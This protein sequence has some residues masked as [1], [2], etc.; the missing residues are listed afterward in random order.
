MSLLAASPVLG[1]GGLPCVPGSLA[2]TLGLFCPH[3]YLEQVCSPQ[4]PWGHTAL[5]SLPGARPVLLLVPGLQ[6]LGSWSG[7]SLVPWMSLFLSA[8]RGHGCLPHGGEA[9]AFASL[10][11]DKFPPLHAPSC[12]NLMGPIPIADN[13]W[14]RPGRLGGS[15][16]WAA[17]FC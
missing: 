2:L 13:I 14:A 4:A 7:A 3:E 1:G 8:S 5:G 16:G 6:A 17:A 11:A 12:P 9:R 10:T 15:V